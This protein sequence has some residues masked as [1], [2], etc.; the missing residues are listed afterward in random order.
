M[1]PCGAWD[2]VGKHCL[3]FD[4]LIDGAVLKRN[5]V[6]YNFIINVIDYV[7]IFY[8]WNTL[9]RNHRRPLKL[10]KNNVYRCERCSSAICILMVVGNT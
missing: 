6:E 1:P 4:S 8:I 3:G 9:N 7:E 2:H 10:K 5:Y